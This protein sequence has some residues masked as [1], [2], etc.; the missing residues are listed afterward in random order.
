MKPDNSKLEPENYALL[1]RDFPQ[2]ATDSQEVRLLWLDLGNFDD[3]IVCT[4]VKCDIDS[5]SYEALS[6][7]WEESRYSGLRPVGV[8]WEDENEWEDVDDSDEPEVE[9]VVS[10]ADRQNT[11]GAASPSRP[12]A[13]G[14][15]NSYKPITINKIAVRVKSNL[16]HALRHLRFDNKVRTLWIDYLCINQGSIADRNAQ[17]RRMDLI[18]RKASQVIA[19][20]GLPTEDSDSALDEIHA[21]TA[22][23]HLGTRVSSVGQSGPQILHRIKPVVHLM[24]RSWFLRVWVVQEVALAKTAIVQIGSRT[25]P[26]DWFL[27][28][29]RVIQEHSICCG[30]LLRPFGEMGKGCYFQSFWECWANILA[31][32]IGTRDNTTLHM[33]L[34]LFYNRQATDPRDKVY[35]LLG[36]LTPSQRLVLPNYSLS[37]SEVYEE[38]AFA[39]MDS[40]KELSILMD[41][42]EF[43]GDV[44][45]PSWCPDWTTGCA[46]G[47]ELYDFYNAGGDSTA[48]VQ[49]C[50]ARTLKLQG[51]I[52][53]AVVSVDSES[54]NDTTEGELQEGYLHLRQWEKIANLSGNGESSYPAGGIRSAAFCQ[55]VLMGTNVDRTRQ[56]KKKDFD[57][58]KSWR[59]WLE[60][61]AQKEPN[62]RNAFLEAGCRDPSIRKHNQLLVR[63]LPTRWFFL[64][65]DGYMGLGP[66]QMEQEDVV[67]VLAG[68]KTPFVLR[69]INEICGVCQNGQACYRLKGFAYVHGIMNGE[70]VAGIERQEE[71]WSEFCLR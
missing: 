65:E 21:L 46:A 57:R 24:H 56:L 27:K 51:L 47:M 12:K 10:E 63:H 14:K 9:E 5:S 16:E 60:E 25:V 69:A 66:V 61:Y 58:W 26:W 23:T 45:V 33:A 64:T 32:G 19:W 43:A 8:E 18:Y 71:H 1:Y 7:T 38:T 59:E 13:H 2:L 34:R 29:A 22:N 52:L 35:G 4:L 15:H 6:Y 11:Q 44:E 37:A 70:T 53:D 36:L 42:D 17:V 39:I 3:D 55:T 20:I 40:S 30:D 48:S 62:C 68:A 31:V 49:R 50:S 28:A 67:C 54:Y 41:I